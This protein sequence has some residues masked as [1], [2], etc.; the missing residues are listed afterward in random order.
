MGNDDD[1]GDR[2]IR[3]E[4]LLFPRQSK[5]ARLQYNTIYVCDRDKEI[6]ALEFI[7][8]IKMI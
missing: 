6:N 8:T 5:I 1:E 3:I 7:D 2:T 4:L